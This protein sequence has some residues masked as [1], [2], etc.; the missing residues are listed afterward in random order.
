[1]A[2]CDIV[3]GEGGMAMKENTSELAEDMVRKATES[4]QEEQLIEKKFVAAVLRGTTKRDRRNSQAPDDATIHYTELPESEP[5]S[6]IRQEW[7]FYRRKVAR[8]LAE[9]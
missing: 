7:N 8:L 2:V 6:P 4:L 1:M 9:G 3:P 5:D